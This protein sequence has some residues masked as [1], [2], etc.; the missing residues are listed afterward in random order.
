MD[1]HHVKL[2]ADGLDHRVEDVREDIDVVELDRDRVDVVGVRQHVAHDAVLAA[3]DVDL[4]EHGAAVADPRERL[5]DR[6]AVA[7]AIT[8]DSLLEMPHAT[9]KER[10]IIPPSA[11]GAQAAFP[12]PAEE[13]RRLRQGEE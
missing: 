6:H 13:T 10:A 8:P 7:T 5:T 3:L 4:E 11:G 2:A 9:A 12:Q 1:V